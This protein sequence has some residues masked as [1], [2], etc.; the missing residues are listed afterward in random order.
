VRP[1]FAHF[2]LYP[3]SGTNVYL[4]SLKLPKWDM[5][6]WVQPEQTTTDKNTA[7]TLPCGN[8]ELLSFA[9]GSRIQWHP[10]SAHGG[11]VQY[12]GEGEAIYT[13][14]PGFSGVDTLTYELANEYGVTVK[15]SI[16]ITVK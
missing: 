8:A 15:K 2:K 9:K 10:V 11:K 4:N 7:L 12:R 3:S 13:P 16:N 6:Y 14:A 1:Y 5:T